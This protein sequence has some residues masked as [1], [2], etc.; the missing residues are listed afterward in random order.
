RNTDDE[1]PCTDHRVLGRDRFVQAQR[2][3]QRS[4]NA[5][6]VGFV[7]IGSIGTPMAIRL[8]DVADSLFVYD[9][10][11]EALDPVV[12]QGASPAQSPRDVA[13][14][15]DAVALSL[16]TKETFL[17]ATLGPDGVIHGTRA[18]YIL[19]TSTMGLP[20]VR[21]VAAQL[22]ARG[23]RVVDC[24]I[25]GGVR[26]ARDGTL[27]VMVSGEQQAVAAM[28]PI[29]ERWGKVTI[30]GDAPGAAQALKLTNNILS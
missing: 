18:K 24:P 25:S 28:R 29:L 23:M 11:K 22:A 14:R 2:C 1:R 20:C 7:G 9:V 5:V 6:N 17:D 13:D 3:G 16:P 26:G 15:V 10:R 12:A 4:G 8:L 27:S 19:N 30:V 21:D